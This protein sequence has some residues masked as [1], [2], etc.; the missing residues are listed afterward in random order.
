M[1]NACLKQR[2]DLL[3]IAV[4]FVLSVLVYVGV[5]GVTKTKFEVLGVAAVP[6]A[7]AICLFILALLKS[8]QVW[9]KAKREQAE[10]KQSFKQEAGSIAMF[11]LVVAFVAL[12]ALLSLSFWLAVFIFMVLAICIQQKPT[13]AQDWIKLCL[14]SLVFALGVDYL[15]TKVFYFGL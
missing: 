11:V 7:L 4:S 12:I 6:R 14:F 1:R 3:V 8:V 5:Y 9:R 10:T 2:Y 13:C 15:F